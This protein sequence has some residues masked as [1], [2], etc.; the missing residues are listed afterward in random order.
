MFES[1]SEQRSHEMSALRKRRHC[2]KQWNN[3]LTTSI[4][5]SSSIVFSSTSA[6]TFA[7]MVF[8]KEQVLLHLLLVS[9]PVV[10]NSWKVD[11]SQVSS[12]KKK[13]LLFCFL[14]HFLLT[15][16]WPGQD[17]ASA[18]FAPACILH[19]LGLQVAPVNISWVIKKIRGAP[20]WVC[21]WSSSPCC[22]RPGDT[23]AGGRCQPAPAPCTQCGAS[24]PGVQVIEIGDFQSHLMCN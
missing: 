8:G 22:W 15:K 9:T 1:F 13:N 19:R 24:P 3:C 14:K 12:W 18:L 17:Q 21:R 16:K 2:W 6:R 20:R 23:L 10:Q 5:F 7:L 11:P 4:R